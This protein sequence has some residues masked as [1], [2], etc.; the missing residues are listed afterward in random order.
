MVEILKK[1]FEGKPE[2]STIAVKG[3]CWDC[4]C[5]TTIEVTS[6]SGGF[7]FMGGVLFKDPPDGYL[8]KCLTCCSKPIDR[9]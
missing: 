1:M 7:G 9:T 6:T 8:M 4:K 2:K 3:S 5:E